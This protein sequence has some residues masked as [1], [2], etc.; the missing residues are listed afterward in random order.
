MSARAEANK[1]SIKLASNPA[2]ENCID[3]G[4]IANKKAPKVAV[5][6]LFNNAFAKKNTL[7]MVKVPNNADGKR[8]ANSPNPNTT[9]VGTSK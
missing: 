7:K 8:M 1:K 3:H 4:E 9:M 6:Q 5:F 2:L